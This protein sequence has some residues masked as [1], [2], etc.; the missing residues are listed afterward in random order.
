MVNGG[1]RFKGIVGGFA[2][3]HRLLPIRHHPVVLAVIALFILK[4][5]LDITHAGN[6]HHSFVQIGRKSAA[7]KRGVAAIAAAD[8]TH[9]AGIDDALANQRVDAIR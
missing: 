3:G 2:V 7:G 5:A 8:N 6:R 1:Y 4:H 9:P